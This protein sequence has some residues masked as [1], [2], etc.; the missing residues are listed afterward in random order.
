MCIRLTKR[1]CFGRFWLSQRTPTFSEYF[2][3]RFPN[4]QF[5]IIVTFSVTYR[6][7]R[8]G[9]RTITLRRAFPNGSQSMMVGRFRLLFRFWK[10]LLT[11][12]TRSSGEMTF[13]IC[14]RRGNNFDKGGNFDCRSWPRIR[15]Y[16]W[17]IFPQG[18]RELTNHALSNDETLKILGLSWLPCEDA[19]GFAMSVPTALTRCSILSFVSKLYDPLGWAAPVIIAAKI[20]LQGL[21]LLKGDWNVPV[22][23]NKLQL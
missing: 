2:G 11:S 10:I 7:V 4:R 18:Q 3:G 9:V 14:A 13:P 12:M 21:W 20:L 15:Q 6:Y 22:P 17:T 5:S 16:F 23:P 8:P 1:K 19:F